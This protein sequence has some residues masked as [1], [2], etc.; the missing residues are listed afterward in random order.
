MRPAPGYRPVE[1]FEHAQAGVDR[2]GDMPV[3]RPHEDV[4]AAELVAGDAGEVGRDAVAGPDLGA[5]GV[6]AL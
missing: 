6:L 4:T 5:V 2:A 3:V 1:R